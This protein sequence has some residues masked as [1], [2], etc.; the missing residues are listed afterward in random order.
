MTMTT[1]LRSAS[2][3][4]DGRV[5]LTGVYWDDYESFL[6]LLEDHAG[7]R[8]YY[9]EGEMEIVTTSPKHERIKAMIGR[10]LSR[11]AFLRRVDLRAYG[12]TTFKKKAAE[13][14]A[15]PDECYVVGMELPD[16]DPGTLAPYSDR[17]DQLDAL[18]EFDADV[19]GA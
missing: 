3:G 16:L 18:T 19:R 5:V 6:A 12:S 2:A 1:A 15:E 9:L 7:V 10:L 4:R 13:S 8:L 14:G 17:V 11:Y